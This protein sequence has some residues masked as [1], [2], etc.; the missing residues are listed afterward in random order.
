M[1][2]PDDEQQLAGCSFLAAAPWSDRPRRAN[3]RRF[4]VWCAAVTSSLPVGA[5]RS[6]LAPRHL[7]SGRLVEIADVAATRSKGKRRSVRSDAWSRP[8]KQQRARRGWSLLL[9]S[10]RCL[11]L[12]RLLA[13][14]PAD[15]TVLL[16]AGTE[17]RDVSTDHGSSP[18]T[19]PIAH[20]DAAR[21]RGMSVSRSAIRINPACR[22]PRGLL[23]HGRGAS[24]RRGGVLRARRRRGF[25]RRCRGRRGFGRRCRRCG[26]ADCRRWGGRRHRRRRA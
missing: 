9:T 16:P 8:Q 13:P 4:W 6:C 14:V 25:G 17:S 21:S 20:P 26:L 3:R 2:A 19:D 7:R 1:P 18:I 11:Q 24:G 22:L 12:A 23:R 5:E 10:L 15:P